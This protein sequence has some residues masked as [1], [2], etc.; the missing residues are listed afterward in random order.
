MSTPTD[1]QKRAALDELNQA[2]NALR[3][4]GT[5]LMDAAGEV[6]AAYHHQWGAMGWFPADPTRS[7]LAIVRLAR[8]AT[9][10]TPAADAGPSQHPTHPEGT[11]R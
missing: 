4:A 6:L 1:A 3:A 7:D 8:A 10:Q 5:P 11:P 2:V 9:S